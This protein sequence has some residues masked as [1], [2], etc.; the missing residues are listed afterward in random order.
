MRLSQRQER[1]RG[2]LWSSGRLGTGSVKGLRV[3]TARAARS[4]QLDAAVFGPGVGVLVVAVLDFCEK[5]RGFAPERCDHAGEGE[6]SHLRRNTERSA[7]LQK[8]TPPHLSES[9]RAGK[10]NPHGQLTPDRP[11]SF[12]SF[13]TRNYYK[14][15]SPGNNYSLACRNKL[16]LSDESTPAVHQCSTLLPRQSLDHRQLLWSK[17]LPPQLRQHRAA[18]V[19][20]PHH[21]AIEHHHA[22]AQFAVR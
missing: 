21:L 11:V 19:R 6:P 8:L 20:E 1:L 13:E 7:C 10:R 17:P 2:A 14:N 3:Q 4:S 16:S 12:N 15:A 22:Q 18:P 9:R 5:A